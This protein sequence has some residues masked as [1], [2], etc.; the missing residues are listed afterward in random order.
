MKTFL[1]ITND[2]W[3][4]ASHRLPIAK[5]LVAL[6][7]TVVVAAKRDEKALEIENAG[8]KF[9]HW[10]IEPRGTHWFK[11][12]ITFL[13]LALIIV[14]TRP[15]VVHLVTIKAVLYGGLLAR[16]FRIK[17]VVCAVS[18]LGAILEDSGAAQSKMLKLYKLAVKHSRCKLIFQNPDNQKRLCDLLDIPLES[19]VLIVGSGVDLDLYEHKPEPTGTPVVTMAARL[20]KDK[21]VSEFL[22]AA[23][24]LATRGIKVDMQLAGDNA[25]SGNPSA[26]SLEELKEITTSPCMRYLGFVED[27]ATLFTKSNLVVLPSYH[28]GL[29]KVLQEAAA[30]GRAVVTSEAP[31]CVFAVE[32]NVTALVVPVADALALTNAIEKL[33]VDVPL[34]NDFGK[35]GR[36]A[37]EERFSVGS[38]VDGHMVAY[39]EAT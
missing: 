26:Y 18:G 4:F 34:R 15:D 32:P 31:G 7:H 24:M 14:R 39:G 28:E 22:A 5:R 35:A 27:T 10:N 6:G 9:V 30:C 3:F 21:G 13:E 38:I 1:F 12:L 20:L 25:G 8:C 17:Q 23:E 33:V 19:S 37:A 2:A 11:E 36:V 29:P 16:F